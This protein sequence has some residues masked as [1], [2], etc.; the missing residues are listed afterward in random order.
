MPMVPEA[1]PSRPPRDM[2]K[3][4]ASAP[5]APLKKRAVG[6]QFSCMNS[7]RL[8]GRREPPWSSGTFSDVG[9]TSRMNATFFTP[10][11]SRAVVTRFCASS[12]RAVP[13]RETM[14]SSAQT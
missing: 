12:A 9:C 5:H 13:A 2:P 7:V 11:T 1:S 8:P 10:R 3:K 4:P 14:P 6:D